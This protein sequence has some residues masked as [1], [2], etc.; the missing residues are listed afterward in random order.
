MK[1]FRVIEDFYAGKI[2]IKKGS[3]LDVINEGFF[4]I[5][6]KHKGKVVSIELDQ[7]NK[8]TVL[9]GGIYDR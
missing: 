5:N 4:R 7:K 3:I 6:V 8:Y 2:L 9:V 1:Q